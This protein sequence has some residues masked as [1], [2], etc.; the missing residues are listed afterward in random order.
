VREGVHT[1]GLEGSEYNKDSCPAVIE[2]ERK[3]NEEFICE[4]CGSMGLLNDIVDMLRS[5]YAVSDG[6]RQ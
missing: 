3:M 5:S 1:K 4:I 2:G 6:T